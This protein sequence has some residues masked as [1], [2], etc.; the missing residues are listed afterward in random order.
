MDVVLLKEIGV[1]DGIRTRVTA[2]KGRC[3]GPLD[4]GD[5]CA[6]FPPQALYLVYRARAECQSTLSKESCANDYRRG[7]RRPMPARTLRR[8]S[9]NC[10]RM[11]LSVMPA[12]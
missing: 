1:P 2:V 9:A 4:D 10:R 6:R 12:M 8:V 5:A 11:K 3:P 7:H